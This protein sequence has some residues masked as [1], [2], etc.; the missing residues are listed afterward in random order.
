MKAKRFTVLL[1]LAVMIP[2]HSSAQERN[3]S[4]QEIG[5]SFG[6]MFPV[7][8][9]NWGSDF[10]YGITYSKYYQNG[11][12]IRTG[13]QY[14]TEIAQYHNTVGVPVAAVYR[15]T[16][17]GWDPLE[18]GV[19]GAR[20][21]AMSGGGLKDVLTSSLLSLNRSV[22]FFLGL[23]PGVVLDPGNRLAAGSSSGVTEIEYYK[24]NSYPFALSL[25][26][27]LSVNY[28]IGRFRAYIIPAFHFVPTGTY[29]LNEVTTN[30]IAGRST[31][32]DIIPR[33][34][35]S[36]SGGLGFAF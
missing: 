27:G 5:F 19:S 11:F 33:W 16:F 17:N 34:M 31:T 18:A 8:G 21:S 6:G 12:G 28:Y 2:I 20:Q 23:T 10:V 36:I 29:K 26:A 32:R 30:T 14:A 15:W 13:L 25:D 7:G 22:D 35:F 24:V 4:D 9:Y 3:M 1:I